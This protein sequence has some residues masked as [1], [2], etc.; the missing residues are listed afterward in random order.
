VDGANTYT[1]GVEEHLTVLRDLGFLTAENTLTQKGVYATEFNEGHSILCTEFFVR[2]VGTGLTAEELVAV[3]ACFIDDTEKEEMPTIGEL[4]VTEPVKESLRALDRIVSQ[5]L[6]AEA[7]YRV[8]S[9]PSYW[10]LSTVWIEPIW[11]WLHGEHAAAI[12]M[13]AGQF[14]GNFVR[15]ILRVANLV[16]EAISVATLRSDLETLKKLET[17]R[18]TLVRDLIVPDSLY[19]HL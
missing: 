4:N 11:R 1:D 10:N 19:L 2:G 14:E 5:C 8:A 7:K 17:V 3:F 18:E 15:S 6:A 16:Q 13:E 9:P 12:C